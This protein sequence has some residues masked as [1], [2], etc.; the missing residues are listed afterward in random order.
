MQLSIAEI[1]AFSQALTIVPAR[2]TQRSIQ[3]ISWDSRTLWRD[4]LFVA[5][6]G[7]RVDGNDFI[8]TAF[9]KGAAVVIASRQPT[10][11]QRLAATR[12]R[13]ALLY[14]P[15]GQ[16]ALQRLAA[17]WRE[18]LSAKVVGVTGS[19]GKTSTKALI[20][21]VVE[22]AFLT[23]ASMGNRNNEIGLPA[24][25]LSASP[26]TEVLVVEMAMRGLGQ[27]AQLAA[28]ARPH[29]GVVTNIGSVHL[30]L[31]GDKDKVAQAK[32]ELITA[33]PAGQG[34]AILNGDDVWTPRIRE[35][36]Q[37]SERDIRVQLFGLGSHNDIRAAHIE[38]DDE[39]RPSFDLWLQDGYPRRVTLNLR[40]KHSV[41][42]ALAAAA[43]G[44]S[45]GV[46]P[47]TLIAALESAPPP[48]MRQVSYTLDDGSFLIDD[49]YNANPDSMRAALEL[50]GQLKRAHPH[51]AVLGDMGELG[52]DEVALHEGVGE[53]VQHNAIDALIT[54]GE[55]AVHYAQGARKAGMD[56]ADIISCLSIDDAL[57]TL[58]VLRASSP[59]ILVKAS[60]FMGLER[61]VEHLVQD[62]RPTSPAD[63]DAPA[64]PATAAT[65]EEAPATPSVPNTNQQEGE[66]TG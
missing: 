34:I 3:K 1:T 20:A 24:S 25:V 10:E 27:I 7:E 28:I 55:L 51:V 11:A 14:V 43:V 46:E 16:L 40:G 57:A 62:A 15:D 45:L 48:P 39:G 18:R 29:I 37:T 5:L 53:I 13:A 65:P 63:V 21:A 22:K 41:Y 42:N 35:L 61:V 17:A 23:V 66:V 32:A 36:A 52:A 54:I 9:E 38:Y 56:E 26:S 44:L 30:E 49:T 50:F 47:S 60:R 31:L 4:A 6:P 64:I 8:I 58:D 2:D 59:V 19:S 12:H 33:L